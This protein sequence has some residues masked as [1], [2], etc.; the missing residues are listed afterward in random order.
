MAILFSDPG[1]IC[2]QSIVEID[3][4]PGRY[5]PH[6][7]ILI[8]IHIHIQCEDGTSRMTG[9]DFPSACK[10]IRTHIR[11]ITQVYG[12]IKLVFKNLT[13]TDILNGISE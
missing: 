6:Q 12:F 3:Q 11:I 2:R 7:G 13:P 8:P 9:Q 4:S 5:I 1:F 10:P